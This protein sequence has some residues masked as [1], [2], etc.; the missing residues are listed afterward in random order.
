MTWVD[1]LINYAWFLVGL[2]VG[3]VLSGV[4]AMNKDIPEEYEHVGAD[5]D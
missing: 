2:C 5:H 3:Y 4:F 1:W